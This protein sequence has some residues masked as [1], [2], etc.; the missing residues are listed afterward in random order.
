MHRSNINSI[1]QDSVKNINLLQRY[2]FPDT[3]MCNSLSQT[4]M[5]IYQFSLLLLPLL[6]KKEILNYS[7]CWRNMVIS[8][9][10]TQ[11]SVYT[12]HF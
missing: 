5:I 8:Y 12:I 9:A 4:C 1:S 11:Y 6:Y 2:V 3:E 7:I 10:I